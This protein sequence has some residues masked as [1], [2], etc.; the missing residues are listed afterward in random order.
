MMWAA[1]SEEIERRNGTVRLNTDVV[2]ILRTGNHIDAVV[3]SQNGQE[4]VV[5]GTDF[6]STMPIRELI[7]KL[8]PPAPANVLK[9][10]KSLVHRDFLTLCLVVNQPQLFPDNWIYIHEASVKVGRI[11]NFKNWSPD[12][13]PDPSKT[14]LGLEYFCN[15]GDEL[16]NTPDEE[17]IELGK[18]ELDKIGM[19]RPK[20]IEDGCVVRV[21]H[22]YPVYDSGYEDHLSV[23]REFV[24]T[25]DNLQT[26]GRNGLHRYN[27]QDHSMLTGM[28]AVRNMVLGEK[29]DL[30]SVN[31]E[32]E[33]HEEVRQDADMEHVSEVV[34][35]AAETVFRRID[36]KAFGLS[37]GMATSIV[38]FLA[39]LW[40][41]LKGGEVVGPNMQ[42]L[43]QYLPGYSVSPSGSA[44]ALGYGFLVGFVCGWGFA[45]LRITYEKAPLPGFADDTPF[46]VIHA[47]WS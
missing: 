38:L 37:L 1:F 6:V 47:Y 43:G 18:R 12:M 4:E 23:V 19:A 33:Y 10:A 3:V 16:W 5:S 13:V 15:A 9:C 21:S 29:N 39:T 7:E 42:L 8:D 41:V 26:I 40:L 2:R 24:S 14:S 11:Q 25:L 20:D 34:H 36:R 44:L 31:A 28:L 30:W 46:D 22:T 45:L 27:N 17:L 35:E 32:Q